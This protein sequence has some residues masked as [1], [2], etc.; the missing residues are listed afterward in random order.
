MFTEV[1][2][3]HAPLKTTTVRGDPC[4]WMTNIIKNLMRKRDHFYRKAIKTKTQEDWKSY[5]D[6]RNEV[7][8]LTRK[9]K[10]NYYKSQ[11]TD[12]NKSPKGI[13]STLKKVLPKSSKAPHNLEVNKRVIY[14]IIYYNSKSV[15]LIFYNN[16][17]QTW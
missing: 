3:I 6:T 16:W 10:D 4:P 12:S 13:W 2:D 1:C 9:E 11:I 5:K 17:F 15:Q 8:T 7:R 14:N